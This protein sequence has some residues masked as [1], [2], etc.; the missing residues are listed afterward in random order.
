MITG[1]VL[2]GRG[3]DR[4]GHPAAPRAGALTAGRRR[5]APRRPDRLRARGLGLPRAAD[6]GDRGPRAGDGGHRGPRAGRAAARREHPGVRGRGDAPRRSSERAGRARPGRRREPPTTV[7]AELAARAID[8]GL[9]VVVDK[10]LAP[11][12][13]EARALV[14]RAERRGVPLTVFHNRRWDSDQLTLRRLIDEGALGRGASLRVAVRALAPA[15]RARGV[16]GGDAAGARRRPPARPRDPS[17]RSGPGAVRAG[18]RGPRRG[19]RAARRRRRRRRLHRAPPRVRGRSHLW[20]SSVAAAPG[21]RLRVLGS[22]G[23]FVVDGST[24]RRRRW[25]RG[26][27]RAPAPNGAREPPDRW[28]RLVRGDEF[29]PVRPEPGAW[30]R[31]YCRLE[32]RCA[33]A[34]R[35][36]SIRADAVTVLELL[37]RARAGL[38]RA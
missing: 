29:E 15:A 28:G 2:L 21:P 24:A 7:H 16:A 38:A 37:E 34:A 26:D 5:R 23:A 30:P 36:R 27:A 25:P 12:S 14:E 1:A 33:T 20:A 4:R 13:A 31:F 3:D 17:R 8:A 22:E 35:R 9:A 19:R 18:G 6:R 10:P 11:T 32:R